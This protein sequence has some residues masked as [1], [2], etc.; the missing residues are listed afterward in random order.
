MNKDLFSIRLLH[1]LLHM[2][3]DDVILV[4]L[5]SALL[6]IH[7]HVLCLCILNTKCNDY[8]RTYRSYDYYLSAFVENNTIN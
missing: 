1:T 3:V 7:I 2:N 6:Y 4:V 8:I 5:R